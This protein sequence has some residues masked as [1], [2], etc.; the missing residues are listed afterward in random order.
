V[1]VRTKLT[2]GA[3][4]GVGIL[5]VVAIAPQG[6]RDREWP[7][8]NR[9][10]RDAYVGLFAS[11]ESGRYANLTWWGAAAGSARGDREGWRFPWR[12]EIGPIPRGA[13][14]KFKI[15]TLSRGAATCRMHTVGKSQIEAPPQKR[16]S[17]DGQVT[18][19]IIVGQ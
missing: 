16:R 1:S 12:E 18:C 14:I 6:G 17:L 11:W 19:S 15:H 7:V 4:V 2:A 13:E 3:V 5:A 10:S 9:A 8:L